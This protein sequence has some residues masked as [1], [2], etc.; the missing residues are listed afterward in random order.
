MQFRKTGRTLNC[1]GLQQQDMTKSRKID[2]YYL[3]CYGNILC[4]KVNGLFMLNS[5]LK[6][7]GFEVCICIPVRSYKH[8]NS[9]IFKNHIRLSP[10]LNHECFSVACSNFHNIIMIPIKPSLNQYNDPY[11][12]SYSRG[13]YCNVHISL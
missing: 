1:G 11:I 8:K 2:F 3:L 6:G 4:S 7:H 13:H 10:S 12:S 9:R 5:V